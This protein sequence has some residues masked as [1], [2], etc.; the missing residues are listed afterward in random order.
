MSAIEK[1]ASPQMQKRRTTRGISTR[2]KIAAVS[3]DQLSRQLTPRTLETKEIISEDMLTIPFT[4]I[5]KSR[6]KS[7]LR[8]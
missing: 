3:H 4:Y 7:F 8:R 1:Y 2:R 5:I 6:I